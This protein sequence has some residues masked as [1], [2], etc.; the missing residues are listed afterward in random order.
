MSPAALKLPASPVF[1][2]ATFAGSR[3]SEIPSVDDIPDRIMVSS[4]R[5]ATALALQAIGAGPG[6]RVL[7]PTYHCPT[8]IAAVVG[9]GAEPVFF[10]I[11]DRGMPD[12]E[13]L[14]NRHHDG[15]RA[16]IVAHYFG[17]PQP[18]TAI[19]SFCDRRGIALIE[20][21]A[22]AMF[23]T[24]AGR[25]IGTWGD[26]AIASLTKFFPV[27]DG[28]YLV[29]AAGNSYPHRP[30]AD[31]RPQR[32]PLRDELKAAANAIELGA[33][34]GRLPGLNTAVRAVFRLVSAVR[35]R[36]PRA[37]EAPRPPGL[38]RT[39]PGDWLDDFKDLSSVVRSTTRLH[40]WIARRAGRERIVGRRRENY[41]RLA[42]LLAT[43]PGAHPLRPELS[44]QA[45]P[46][47]FPLYVDDPERIYQQ[48]RR[49][50]IPVFRWDEVWPSTPAI[51]GDVGLEWATH[52]FQLGC[53]QDLAPGDL[54][55]MA[56]ALR[57]ILETR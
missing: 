48:V 43:L 18:L 17:L 46:Y 7:V 25:A 31:L 30:L 51:P 37:T 45:A 2:W 32:R 1:G 12:L 11:D 3:H 6:S 53:H 8:M 10:P 26:F 4:G 36:G 19:R 44:S 9:V 27:S 54:E 40:A 20:D 56:A 34:Y 28:G 23:G 55:A 49:A 22:H 52:V 15:V 50:G 5:I 33:T 38:Q 47:V 57:A 21:C 29:A 14:E 35:K 16:M 39:L 13:F 41:A 24:A 42:E